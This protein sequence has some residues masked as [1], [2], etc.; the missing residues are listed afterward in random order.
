[1]IFSFAALG[2]GIASLVITI[3]LRKGTPAARSWMEAGGIVDERF[4]LIFMPGFTLLLLGL[5]LLP[6]YLL[7]PAALAYVY[8]V[9]CAVIGA[10]GFILMIWGVIPL[11]YPQWFLPA[12]R[13]QLNEERRSSAQKSTKQRGG[14]G[15]KKTGK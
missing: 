6:H 4:G 9:V 12:W 7:V 3:M 5:G 10:V 14:Q 11:P 15:R 13:R 1:M 8:M 2:V